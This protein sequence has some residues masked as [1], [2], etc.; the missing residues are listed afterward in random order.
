M[1]SYGYHSGDASDHTIVKPTPGG[2]RPTA[3]AARPVETAAFY[4][5]EDVVDLTAGG[6][7]PLLGAAG[8]ILGL[9]RR[10]KSSVTQSDVAALRERIIAEIRTFEKR[11]QQANIPT[12]GA[13]AAHYALCATLDDVVLNTPWG[14]H[15]SWSR[16][17]MVSTFHTD[18]SGGERFFDLLTHIHRDPVANR[19][20]LE[21]M[22]L[23]LSL[24]FEGRLRI[25]PHGSLELSR[26]RDGLYRTL[27][28]QRGDFERELSPHWHGIEA[29]HRPLRS[30]VELWTIGAVAATIITLMITGFSF[31]LNDNSD[32]TL[33]TLATL[34]PTG[35]PSI[36][37]QAPTAP[38]PA[39]KNIAFDH[40]KTF[41]KP[42]IDQGVV[43][44]STEGNTV[45][46]RIRNSGMFQSGSGAVAERYTKLLDRI[47]EAL[48]GEPGKVIITGHTDNVPIR[49]VRFPSNWHLST[50]RAEAVADVISTH[51]TDKD[52][53][54]SEGR[55]E[56]EPIAPNDT[57]DGREANRRIDV[58]LTR[59]TGAQAQ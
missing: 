31:A 49:T 40:L 47:G 9:V 8:P 25:V 20:V 14:N 12:E 10:L 39:P 1:T 2:R 16:S 27:R 55:G 45:T 11:V 38:P 35:T 36:H 24:G 58:I 57:S 28:Q 52:R 15:S 21:L 59:P 54:S 17:G 32:G 37:V 43:T 56:A 34:P 6:L 5:A 33:A 41:L 46:V 26:I 4:R 22:Y 3:A 53:I 18:V 44:V 19:D 51:L 50:A 30:Y 42:E 7:N 23:C 13:R 29:A 48:E